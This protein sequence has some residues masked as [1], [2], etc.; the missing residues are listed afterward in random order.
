MQLADRGADPR[1]GRSKEGIRGIPDLWKRV[2]ALKR[3]RES[4]GYELLHTASVIV[5]IT[6]FMYNSSEWWW[7]PL[8][9]VLLCKAKLTVQRRR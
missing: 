7:L 1:V 6:R 5:S 4:A 9:K 8:R 3:R 2:V